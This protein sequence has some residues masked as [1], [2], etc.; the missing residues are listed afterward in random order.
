MYFIMDGTVSTYSLMKQSIL[1]D[2]VEIAVGLVGIIVG[3]VDGLEGR[4]V[5]SDVGLVG[6]IVGCDVGL[7]EA[8]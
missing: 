1:G 2:E 8:P 4:I 5:G 7:V 3:S 6:I